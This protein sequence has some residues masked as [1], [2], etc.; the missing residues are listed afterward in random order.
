MP[1][2]TSRGYT[3]FLTLWHKFHIDEIVI[4]IY[5]FQKIS[6]KKVLSTMY[7]LVESRHGLCPSWNLARD[8]GAG[9]WLSTKQYGSVSEGHAGNL[10]GASDCQ[11]EWWT[12]AVI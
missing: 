3:S 11:N 5:S 6:D 8:G 1:G 2:H 4:H 9:K 12:S 7:T 10:G